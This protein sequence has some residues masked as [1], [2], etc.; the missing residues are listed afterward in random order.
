M[1]ISYH[2]IGLHLLSAV[3]WITLCRSSSFP[4][5]PP[6]LQ[7]AQKFSA[8]AILCVFPLLLLRLWPGVSHR[9]KGEFK[10]L[11]HHSL[12]AT[13]K[14]VGDAQGLTPVQVP[15]KAFREETEAASPAVVTNTAL[16]F[17]FEPYDLSR[18]L[19]TST[20]L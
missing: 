3:V 11:F 18:S 5:S 9:G 20:I 1:F 6:K 16:S 15:W 17:L 10:T 14:P 8:T 2:F 7:S 4:L 13:C 19:P 12:V